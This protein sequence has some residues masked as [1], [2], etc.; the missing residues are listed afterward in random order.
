MPDFLLSSAVTRST[1]SRAGYYCGS[2][3]DAK[4]PAGKQWPPSLE[5]AALAPAGVPSTGVTPTGVAPRV[6]TP[7]RT[8]LNVFVAQILNPPGIKD[9]ALQA[10]PGMYFFHVELLG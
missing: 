10:L 7:I 2:T 8:A 9:K 3:A 1:P 4:P 5:A 6:S